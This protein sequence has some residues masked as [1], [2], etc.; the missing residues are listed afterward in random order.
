MIFSEKIQKIIDGE[1]AT[2]FAK[3]ENTLNLYICNNPLK[4]YDISIKINKNCVFSKMY[5]YKKIVKL[6]QNTICP[7]SNGYITIQKEIDNWHNFFK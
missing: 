4:K 3:D 7:C 6:N 1:N 2:L 5:N